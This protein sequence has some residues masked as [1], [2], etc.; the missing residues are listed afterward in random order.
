MYKKDFTLVVFIYLDQASCIPPSTT[1]Q[2]ILMN[3]R[4]HSNHM[5]EHFPELMLGYMPVFYPD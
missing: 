2:M 3:Y 4:A 1:T 5:F